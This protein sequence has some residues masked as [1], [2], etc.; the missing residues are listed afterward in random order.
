MVEFKHKFRR[1]YA[2]L[3]K[4]E[5]LV[6][7]DSGSP[8][9]QTTD[10]VNFY[11]DR[12]KIASKIQPQ[13]NAS[14]SD[15]SWDSSRS[16]A[17]LTNMIWWVSVNN[18]WK[19]I[20]DVE[21]WRGLY[22]IDTS[23]TTMRGTLYVKKNIGA[24]DRCQVYFEADLLD[25]RKNALLHVI[26]EPVTLTT[27]SNAADS[28]GIGIGIE[29][30]ITYNPVLDKLSLYE[31]MVANR[32]KTAS[33][34][35]RKKCFD[36]NEYL[37]TIPI[38]VYRAKTKVTTGYSLE[39]YR[40]DVNGKQT[41]I[42]VS[43]KTAPNELM[44]MSLTSMVLDLRLIEKNDYIIKVIVD[45][46]A[47]AQFQ[48]HVNRAY[49]PFEFD[50][51]NV[52]GIAYGQKIRCNRVLV[53]FNNSLVSYPQR[54]LKI[55][56]KTIAHNEGNVTTEKRWQEGDACEYLVEET[57]L[58]DTEN[59]TLEDCVDYGQKP[60]LTYAVGSD[61]SYLTDKDGNPYLIG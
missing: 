20:T 15:K 60:P 23:G 34:A 48:F 18:T 9:M 31:Y 4:S 39:V 2:P 6:C 19:K 26:T 43:T 59:C 13:I 40:V 11:P 17:F 3:T 29:S 42:A 49:P 14:A 24:N 16:N 30:N 45:K 44:S 21:S 33:D 58:G 1:H 36:G 27:A 41:K 52:G 32:L 57:G 35:E 37:R 5:S 53:H 28:W 10:G 12:T 61:G 47:V 22:E 38:D 50:F 46:K 54:I 51:A 8:L 25:Y 56:W 7:L 55:C